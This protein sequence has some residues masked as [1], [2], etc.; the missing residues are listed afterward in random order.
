MPKERN[1]FL[2]FVK[3]GLIFLVTLGHTIQMIWYV[4]DK[5]F[6]FDKMFHGIYSFHMPLFMAISG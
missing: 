6:W 2:D 3:F 1:T 5:L 4:N